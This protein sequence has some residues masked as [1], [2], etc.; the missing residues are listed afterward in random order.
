MA[1]HLPKHIPGKPSVIV[2]NMP[3]ASGLIT[4]NYMFNVAKPNGLTIAH[5]N[6]TIPQREFLRLPAI[7]YRSLDFE[8]LGLANSSVITIAIRADAP[9]QSIEEWLKPNTP[10]LIFG[11]NTRASLTCSVALAMND[12]FGPISKI[13]PGYSGT[14]LVRAAML[15]KEVD[16]LTGWT[17]DSV[18]A[19]GLPMIEAGE[20]KLLAYIGERRHPELE[21][22]KVPF[23]NEFVKKADDQAFLKIL[24][25]PAIMVRPWTTVPGTPKDRVAIL[26]KAFSE[27]LKDPALLK[28]AKRL[29]VDIAPKSAEWLVEIIRKT[30]AELRPEVIT[31]A[32]KVLGVE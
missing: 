5:I 22:R 21:E 10:K 11:C 29:K 27:T 16:A 23:L 13:V 4:A 8:W 1:R 6:Y 32:R 30:K 3:G 31:R 24:M 9:V 7:R 20:I 2:E 19:T 17:W 26:R 28:E 12:I 25:M 18:K 15:R 14:A